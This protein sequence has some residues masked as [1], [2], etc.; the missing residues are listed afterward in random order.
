MEP[1]GFLV[2]APY[3]RCHPGSL[4]QFTLCS[5]LGSSLL[6]PFGLLLP[7]SMCRAYPP[8]SP[9]LPSSICLAP[10]VG[11]PTVLLARLGL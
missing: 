4:L 2:L 7:T 5:P 3:L 8:S 10:V 1:L 9:S 11:H 6:Q